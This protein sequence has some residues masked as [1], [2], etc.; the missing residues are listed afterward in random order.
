MEESMYNKKLAANNLTMPL[1]HP[2]RAP[3]SLCCPTPVSG[4]PSSVL[5]LSFRTQYTDSLTA[6]P[7]LCTI[8]L[9]YPWT[10]L[11][12]DQ[13]SKTPT[14]NRMHLFRKQESLRIILYYLTLYPWEFYTYA[15]N[16]LKPNFQMFAND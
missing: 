7:H 5:S 9:F 6:L 11:F 14:I 13:Q 12:P 2:S 4:Y 3:F 15:N 8:R 16:L 10:C 1:K